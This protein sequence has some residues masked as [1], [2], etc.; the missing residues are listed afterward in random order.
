MR[1]VEDAGC[2]IDLNQESLETNEPS[3]VEGKSFYQY[4]ET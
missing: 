4:L 2:Y 3:E 1:Q